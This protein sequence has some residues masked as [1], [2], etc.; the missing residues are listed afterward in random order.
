[1]VYVHDISYALPV[2]TINEW[3][4]RMNETRVPFVFVQSHFWHSN[5]YF[6]LTTLYI[7]CAHKSFLK[8]R[9]FPLFP[10]LDHARVHRTAIAHRFAS[11]N[12]AESTRE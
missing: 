12:D 8:S 2:D 11:L 7:Q 6:V 9:R 10:S 5:I 4:L 1:M 3:L